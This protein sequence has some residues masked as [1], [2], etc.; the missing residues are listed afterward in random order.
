M[1]FIIIA[2]IIVTVIALLIYRKRLSSKGQTLSKMVAEAISEFNTISNYGKQT[3]EQ[4]IADY[5]VKYAELSEKIRKF[6]FTK[7]MTQQLFDS[8]GIG[9]YMVFYATIDKH[10]QEN[11]R[12][13]SEIQKL[14]SWCDKAANELD[15]LLDDNHYFA[16]SESKQF[17]SHNG[18][19][20]ESF[21]KLYPTNSKYFSNPKA[22]QLYKFIMGME[23]Q[24][25][26]YNKKFEEIQLVKYDDYFDNVLPYSL[27]KQQRN[28]IVCLEDNTLV[29]S[30]AGSGKTSTIIGKA[31][32][33][34]DIR[35]IDPSKLLIVTYTRKAAEE[36]KCRLGIED[37][38]CCTFHSLAVKILSQVEN[39]KPSICSQSLLLNTFGTLMRNDKQFLSSVLHYLLHLQSLMKLEHEYSK[40][41]DYFADRKKYGIQAPYTDM[42]DHIIFTRSEEEKRICTYLTELGVNFLYEQPY[43]YNTYTKDFRQYL[44]DFTIYVTEQTVNPETGAIS[45]RV[46]RVYLEHFAIDKDGNVPKWFGD[47]DPKGGWYAQNRKYNDGIE[48]KR[49]THRNN[50]TTLIETRSADFHSGRIMDVLKEQL[51]KVRVPFRDVPSEELYA[52]L[53]KR[54][55]KV[56]R[57]V[58]ALLE[59][60]IALVKS[61]CPTFSPFK[62]LL[63]TAT[64][65]KDSRTLAIINDIV[66]PLYT[67]YT[68]ELQKLGQIDFTD[69]I[70]LASDYCAM[71]KWRDYDYIL[72]DEF[73]DISVDRY[74]FLQCLR[75]RVPMTK[76]FCVGD[77]WQ[78]IYRFAGSNMRLFYKFEE[79]FGF[80]EHRKIESTYRFCNPLLDLSS[81]FIQRNPEQV[82]KSVVPFVTPMPE[83][84]KDKSQPVKFI[85]IDGVVHPCNEDEIALIQEWIRRNHTYIDFVDCGAS[86]RQDDDRMYQSVQKLVKEIPADESILILGRYNYDAFSVGYVFNQ[87]NP[88]SNPDNIYVSIEGRKIRFMSVHS[89]KG[90]EAD[91]VILINCEEGQN[92]FPSLIE[93]D[94]ILGYVLSEEDQFEY[95]EERRLFYVAITRAKRHTYVLFH[96]DKPSPFVREL[97]NIVTEQENICPLCQQGHIVVMKEGISKNGVPFKNYGCSNSNA[98]CEYF[99]RVFGDNIPNFVKFN[100]AQKQQIDKTSNGLGFGQVSI[101]TTLEDPYLKLAERLNYKRP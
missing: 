39:K 81:E 94:P 92:G 30:S 69:A 83:M 7:M 38:E 82:R 67:A 55:P 50:H 68:D 60:F 2:I 95:A 33:L 74:D 51:T 15:A 101:P 98:G 44:P 25:T 100:E 19:E 85:T 91:N 22:P 45:T 6:R 53:V 42:N 18:F 76:M 23:S 63:E 70:N 54:S 32:Y 66:L 13:N 56:E 89:A 4:E 8:F 88:N 20:I 75:K 61:N 17:Q 48:W 41:P 64:E 29:I 73:Q 86:L 49:I 24:R 35:K 14:D 77:D 9:E 26:Q 3:S 71:G 46:R 90:L 57:S 34:L 93:D 47:K 43:E 10:C 80:T 40:A 27:D 62:K 1:E 87:A 52:R 58:F 31:R 16:F 79:Y 84:R 72:V 21:K 78:S 65:K 12:I 36:L 96:G 97:T 5:K 99:E 11:N 59:Q 37:V 28:A